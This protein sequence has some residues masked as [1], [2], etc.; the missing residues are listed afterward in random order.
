MSSVAPSGRE[1]EEGGKGASASKPQ[2]RQQQ[3]I[4]SRTLLDENLSEFTKGKPL[5]LYILDQAYFMRAMIND[6][7]FLSY[8]KIIDYS[9]LIGVDEEQKALV[10][11]II[12]YMRQYDIIKKMERMG[13]SVGMIAGQAEP[14]VIQPQP[15]RARFLGAMEKY[16][17]G[18][19]DK[20]T[21]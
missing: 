1:K 16:F 8:I 19:P 4:I 14:T 7:S 17:A 21:P 10:V 9:I 6:I 15:Y 2:P 11:G 18:I 3:R 5:P 13:K 12:D 20:W